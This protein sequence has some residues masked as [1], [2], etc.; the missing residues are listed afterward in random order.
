MQ[1]QNYLAIIK[2]IQTVIIDILR[3]KAKKVASEIQYMDD[4]VFLE[5]CAIK[6]L[7]SYPQFISLNLIF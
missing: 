5:T 2:Y 1:K 3:K 6:N 4:I 7:I